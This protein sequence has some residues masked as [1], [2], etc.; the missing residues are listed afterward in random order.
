MHLAGSKFALHVRLFYFLLTLQF[1]RSLMISILRITVMNSVGK[2]IIQ[3][4]Y[5]RQIRTTTLWLQN[6]L[7]LGSHAT[8]KFFVVWTNCTTSFF[9]IEL[10]PEQV[11]T[12]LH[13]Y[14]EKSAATK[15]KRQNKA[16]LILL[17]LYA[18]YMYFPIA[19]HTCLYI[20]YLY[21]NHHTLSHE[22]MLLHWIVA[23]V[24][25]QPPWAQE[26]KKDS[27]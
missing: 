11:H 25:I 13:H 3:R 23:A 18:L 12:P 14:W 21:V 6:K 15:V 8:R 26:F 2:D 7:L 10:S 17:W 16:I 5:W 22:S 24:N 1:Y 9:F 19:Q 27:I 4:K 20:Y